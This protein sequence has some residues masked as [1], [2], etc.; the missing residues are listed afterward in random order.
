MEFLVDKEAM[1][2]SLAPE[3]FTAVNGLYKIREW[4][5]DHGLKWVPVTVHIKHSKE[6]TKRKERGERWIWFFIIRPTPAEKLQPNE[7]LH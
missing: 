7:T 1:S 3:R 2:R 6:K 5:E 4:V